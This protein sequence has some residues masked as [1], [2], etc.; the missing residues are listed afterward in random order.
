MPDFQGHSKSG[1][2]NLAIFHHFLAFLEI[3]TYKKNKLL[4]I[5][6]LFH[7]LH[8]VMGAIITKNLGKIP[9]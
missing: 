5:V 1:M 8:C 3:K 9:K 7:N 2:Q 4:Q 6:L